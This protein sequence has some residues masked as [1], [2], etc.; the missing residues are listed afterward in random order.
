MR[1]SQA[2]SVI[3]SALNKPKAVLIA[4]ILFGAIHLATHD[5]VGKLLGLRSEIKRMGTEI[6]AMKIQ[7]SA[8]DQQL[9]RAKDPLFVEREAKDQLDMA[10]SDDLIFTFSD[11]SDSQ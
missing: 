2:N 7:L 4:C 3:I 9:V 6:Q 8:L 11:D 5:T 1:V 10:S